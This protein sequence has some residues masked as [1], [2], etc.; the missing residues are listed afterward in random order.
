MRS[1]RWVLLTV[2][3]LGG[4]FYAWRTFPRAFSILQLDLRM[5]RPAAL[6]AAESLAV[7][8]GF[9]PGH[10]VRT[11][12]VFDLDGE[13]QTF[14]ELEGGG[15]ETFKRAVR[16]G[17]YHAYTWQVRRVAPEEV[18]ETWI[19]FTPA[20]RPYGFAETIAE[21]APGPSL[22]RDSARAIADARATVDWGVN[23]A[24]YVLLDAAQERRAS[25]RVD[26][27]FTYDAREQPFGE[28]RLRLRLQVTGD[29]LSR[30]ERFLHVP[31]GFERRYDHIRAAND[32]IAEAALAVMVVLYGIGGVGVGLVIMLRRRMILW[33]PAAVAG[34]LFGVLAAASFL[35]AGPFFWLEYDTTA[36][37]GTFVAVAVGLG[38]IA[39]LVTALQ[40]G[41]SAMAAETLSRAAFPSHPQFWRLWSRQAGASRAILA[42]SLLGYLLIGVFLGYMVGFW[43]VTTSRLGWWNPTETLI[44]PNLFATYLPWLGPVAAALQAGFWEE[45][46]FRAVPLASAAL[47]A[48]RFGRRRL[49]LGAALVIQ[50]LVFSA[51]HANYPAQPAYARLV[52]LVLPSL[53]FAGV[54]L[55]WGLLPAIVLHAGFDLTLMAMP[56]FAADS[57]GIW[58]DRG[59]VL[60]VSLLPLGVVA[61]RRANTGRLVALPDTLRNGAWTPPPPGRTEGPA[62]QPPRVPSALGVRWLV[63]LGVIGLA[64][65]AWAS[66]WSAPSVTLTASRSRAIA[67]AR[68]AA[69]ARAGPLDSSWRPLASAQNGLAAADRAHRFVWET[70]GDSAYDALLGNALPGPRWRVRFARFEGDVAERAEEWVVRIENESDVRAVEHVL[71]ESRP[72][73]RLDE[74]AARALADSVVAARDDGTYSLVAIR[75]DQRPARTDWL[76]TYG[77]SAIVLPEGEVRARVEILGDEVALVQRFVF[78]PE[79][80][81]RAESAE[82]LVRALPTLVFGAAFFI[83]F[84][85]ALVA[86][87]VRAARGQGDRRVALILMAGL[88]PL[89]LLDAVSG[90]PATIP[91]FET[92]RPWEVQAAFAAARSGLAAV[93]VPAVFVTILAALF[94]GAVARSEGRSRTWLPVGLLLAGAGAALSSLNAG[95]PALDPGPVDVRWPL[96]TLAAGVP[97]EFV[98]RLVFFVVPFWVGERLAHRAGQLGRVWYFVVGGAIAV[99]SSGDLP[100]LAQATAFVAGAVVFALLAAVVRTAGQG[101]LL[102]AV[103]LWQALDGLPK[104]WSGGSPALFGFIL[105]LGIA[106]FLAW[107]AWLRLPPMSWG[108]SEAT[109]AISSR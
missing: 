6:A 3:S 68:A 84:L 56:I 38:L 34:G 48:E 52:E 49:W 102:G 55:R 26:H 104:A 94:P 60:A 77:D 47:L 95:P 7:A 24:E 21:D 63:P 58:W 85:V 35:N 27:T 19:E 45:C 101:I 1:L 78:V 108:G 91:D 12:V 61:W 22:T 43:Q 96:V 41:L 72:G 42:R 82:S 92:S 73:A 89:G 44:Q 107:A 62:L 4:A 57:P 69:E 2:L 74:A 10:D 88:V 65:W 39:G 51:A 80:W 5:D 17:I 67:L 66:D 103:L 98:T 15:P 86:S 37:V 106:V 100:L 87:V 75:S 79:T 64:A 105:G 11:A 109:E 36:P 30:L 31:E 14:I 25:G 93:M 50:A 97:S 90:W 81:D 13:A 70:A 9:G 76:V 32:A 59:M 23:W 46:L 40:V 29:R 71:P 53:L 8:H 54:Y 83:L 99:V 33:R 16:D 18:N 20:G 28:G